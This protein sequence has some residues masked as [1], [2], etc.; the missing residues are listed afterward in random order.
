MIFIS[1]QTVIIE[2]LC[3]KRN[4]CDIQKYFDRTKDDREEQSLIIA[5]RISRGFV[6]S[7]FQLQIYPFSHN[8]IKILRF[9]D[10][11]IGIV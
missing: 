5:I 1:E 7:D 8:I 10:S 6:F 2:D 11:D 4:D 9:T 3:Y